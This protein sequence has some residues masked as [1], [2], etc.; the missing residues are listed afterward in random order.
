MDKR[1]QQINE[2]LIHYSLGN[3]D[4][5]VELSQRLDDIDT[6]ISGVNM[7][8][9]E[10]KSTTISR[11]YFNNIFHSVSDILLVL[12]MDGSI[13]MVNR[14]AEKVLGAWEN[15]LLDVPISRIFCNLS[16]QA[17]REML[18]HAGQSDETIS[19]RAELKFKNRKFIDADC[20]INLIHNEQK[21]RIGYL[22]IA[23]DLNKVKEQAKKLKKAEN[24]YRKIFQ[25]TSDTIFICDSNF[26]I[27]EINRAGLELLGRDEVK[28][29]HLWQ[30]FADEREKQ[31]FEQ[32]LKRNKSIRNFAMRLKN[33]ENRI[34]DCLIS[35]NKADDGTSNY[36]GII[37]DISHR[38]ELENVVIKTILH[39]QEEERKRLAKDLHDSLGQQL[40]ALMFYINTLRDNE[41]ISHQKVSEIL[42]KSYDAIS[43][44]ATELR[45]V[46]FNLMPRTL[47]NYGLE[48]AIRE[49]CSKIELHG[50]LSFKL[51]ME[52]SCPRLNKDIEITLFR[53]VQEFINNSIKHSRANTIS[54]DMSHTDEQLFIRLKDN[55]IG[56]DIHAVSSSGGMGLGNIRSRLA[57]YHGSVIINSVKGEGT[58]YEITINYK[59]DKDTRDE[60]D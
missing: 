34:I 41:G 52:D 13:Q 3:F 15:E 37:K 17:I 22:V 5:K 8:G 29:T 4:A 32:A 47:E 58:T 16:P 23:R 35:I 28:P 39:T 57:L 49:L 59:T 10:L 36:Q 6:F 21:Q 18:W 12:N 55:G 56:F 1:L 33:F 26:V 25:E 27:Q 24:R 60:K 44:A 48:H 7:L 42:A 51:L 20:S 2:L 38:K 31:D 9:E 40:S 19:I 46:C 30:Y 14:A 50:I 54:I 43:N 11:N 45:N 53:I